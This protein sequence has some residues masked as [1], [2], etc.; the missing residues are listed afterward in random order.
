[1]TP[2]PGNIETEHTVESRKVSFVEGEEVIAPLVIAQ[3]CS[4]G[5]VDAGIRRLRGWLAHACGLEFQS[6]TSDSVSQEAAGCT[7]RS[8]GEEMRKMGFM[9]GTQS[10]GVPL[11][12]QQCACRGS[13]RHRLRH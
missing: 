6:K 12:I 8:P 11:A 2:A 1:M 4:V 3:E 9:V 7:T 5:N 10:S 13:K